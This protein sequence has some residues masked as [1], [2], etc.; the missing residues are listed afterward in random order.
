MPLSGE[1]A[2]MYSPVLTV[3]HFNMPES[4]KQKPEIIQILS[5]AVLGITVVLVSSEILMF[6]LVAISYVKINTN[7]ICS[8]SAVQF[9]SDAIRTHDL[10]LFSP[11]S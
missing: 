1:V 6:P 8:L 4:F 7:A 9:G 10:S 2:D 5:M 3:K 11:V